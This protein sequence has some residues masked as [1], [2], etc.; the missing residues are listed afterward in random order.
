MEL[1][2]SLAVFAAGLF[3]GATFY[4][5]AVAQPV[6]MRL[7]A[8]VALPTYRGSLAR[9]ERLNPILHLTTV[10]CTL[11]ACTGGFSPQ[12]LVAL[13]LL[14]PMIPFTLIVIRP[15]LGILRDPEK[16]SPEEA[17]ALLER[18]G[19]LHLVRTTL[20]AAAFFVLALRL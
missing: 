10:L 19:R 16:A 2:H 4:V 9:S 7:G 13:A 12:R 17:M 5:S 18:W 8:A 1:F 14:A 20:G 6:R 11:A 3:S 15:L